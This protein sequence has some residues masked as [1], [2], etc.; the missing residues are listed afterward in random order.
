[1][2]NSVVMFTFLL[3]IWCFSRSRTEF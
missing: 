2:G 3:V 1:L